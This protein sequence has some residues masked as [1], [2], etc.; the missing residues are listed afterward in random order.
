MMFFV[1]PFYI[2][3]LSMAGSVALYI[4]VLPLLTIFLLAV[5]INVLQNV[6]PQHLP[7]KLKNWNFLPLWMRSLDPIDR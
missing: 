6:V 4:G 5:L 3:A 7:E 2:F 1:I